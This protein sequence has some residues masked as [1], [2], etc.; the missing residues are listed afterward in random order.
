[1]F[2]QPPLHLGVGEGVEESLKVIY[3]ELVKSRFYF[4]SSEAVTPMIKTSSKLSI[5]FLF[6]GKI[7]PYL[8]HVEI[9]IGTKR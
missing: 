8:I 7:I 2:R 5:L 1:M 3:P 4:G 9:L 6:K